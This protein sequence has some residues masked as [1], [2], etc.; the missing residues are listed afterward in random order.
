MIGDRLKRFADTLPE[1]EKEALYALCEPNWDYE[2]ID[3]KRGEDGILMPIAFYYFNGRTSPLY[4]GK[5]IIWRREIYPPVDPYGKCFRFPEE[6]AILKKYDA[7][8]SQYSTIMEPYPWQVEI[9]RGSI[10]DPELWCRNWLIEYDPLNVY[11]TN[12]LWDERATV[13]HYYQKLTNLFHQG[14]ADRYHKSVLQKELQ[15]ELEITQESVH[16]I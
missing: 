12:A 3:I 4:S 8:A 15:K 11:Y 13:L 10:R 7:L 14:S 1:D 5:E 16:E 6:E 9:F 2:V